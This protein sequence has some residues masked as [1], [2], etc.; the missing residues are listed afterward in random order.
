[1]PTALGYVLQAAWRCSIAGPAC[2]GTGWHPSGQVFSRYL[3]ELVGPGDLPTI[4]AECLC[5]LILSDMPCKGL[6]TKDT[7]CSNTTCLPLFSLSQK[8]ESMALS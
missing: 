4:N 1:M 5:V 2:E 7:C 3:H 8:Q 6:F